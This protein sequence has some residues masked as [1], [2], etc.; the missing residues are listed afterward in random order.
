MRPFFP[1]LIAACLSTHAAAADE[2]PR[3]IV[4][5]YRLEFG[6]TDA[7]ATYLS[8]LRY[9]GQTA[10]FSAAWSKSF[11]DN[12][13]TM[14]MRFE[15][16]GSLSSMLNPAQTAQMIGADG[17]FSWGM[18]YR[19]RLP[20]DI[21]LTAGGSLE[22]YG[23][24]LYSTRNGNNPV[25]PNV[26]PAFAFDASASWHFTIGIIPC[27]IYNRA[28]IPA[29]GTFMCPQYGETFYE[30]YLG[31]QEGLSHGGSWSNSFRITDR[32]AMIFD[33]GRTSWE[34][35]YTYRHYRTQA[36]HIT[37]AMNFH[38]ISIG[39]I[40]HGIGLRKKSKINSPLY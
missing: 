3:P 1:L 25:W 11:H 27:L 7:R 5:Q 31:N 21:Q 40:P 4:Q 39:V 35:G 36:N 30:V 15:T 37:T 13:E 16:A 14:L 9:S 34:L 23:G 38:T 32:T 2:L 10:G 28:H 24:V 8:P 17:S 33:C 12:P 6:S 22:M 20:L 29:L 19:K 26:Y 18:E